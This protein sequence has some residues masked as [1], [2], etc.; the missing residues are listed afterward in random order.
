MDSRAAAAREAHRR[1]LDSEADAS[2]FR[3]RRDSYVMQLHDDGYS[4]GW[5]AREI[6]CSKELIATIV[7]R[8]RHQPYYHSVYEAGQLRGRLHGDGPGAER[9]DVE[10]LD[11]GDA[12]DLRAA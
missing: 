8:L 6:R 2:R 4:Y 1:S 11:I 7:R 3:E 12:R 10:A 9:R 5:I